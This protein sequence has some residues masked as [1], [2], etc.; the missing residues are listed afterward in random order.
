M[1]YLLGLKEPINEIF[2]NKIGDLYMISFIEMTLDG[3]SV[4]LFSAEK[5]PYPEVVYTR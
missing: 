2:I 4:D 5:S 3:K 1:A